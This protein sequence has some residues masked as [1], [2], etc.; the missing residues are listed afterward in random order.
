M[1]D[2]KYMKVY[3]VLTEGCFP[4]ESFHD[5]EGI[6]AEKENALAHIATCK[7]D[8]IK[9]LDGG[10]YEYQGFAKGYEVEDY[11]DGWKITS[12]E[13]SEIYVEYFVDCVDVN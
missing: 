8:F 10:V 9:N 2:C 4:C 7:Q 1:K 5:Y 12:K 6:Y 13:Y 11:E 3:I